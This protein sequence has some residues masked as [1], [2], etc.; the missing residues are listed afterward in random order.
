MNKEGSRLPMKN[1]VRLLS[2]AVGTL[3]LIAVLVAPAGA[4]TVTHDDPRFDALT[5]VDITAVRAE[6]TAQNLVVEVTAPE[7]RPDP[8]NPPA[9]TTITWS[10]LLVQLSFRSGPQTYPGERNW[11]V[12]LAEAGESGP[13]RLL[14]SQ[15]GEDESIPRECPTAAY[16]LGPG[17]LTI[18]VPQ[19]CFG[20]HAGTV[21]VAT[22]LRAD[23]D[24]V[25]TDD[26]G[27]TFQPSAIDYTDWSRWVSRA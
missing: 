23:A 6:N 16:A 26:Y 15:T 3:S 24:P 1:R 10:L 17:R 14:L 27:I 11:D 19:A 18:T 20:R 5:Q 21:R 7:F 9:Q 12:E 22:Q 13:R 25:R 4:A 8:P 2:L